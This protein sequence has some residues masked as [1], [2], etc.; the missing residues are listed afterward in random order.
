MGRL[1]ESIVVLMMAACATWVFAGENEVSAVRI[2]GVIFNKLGEYDVALRWGA[3]VREESILINDSNPRDFILEVTKPNVRDVIEINMKKGEEDTFYLALTPSVWGYEVVTVR[4]GAIRFVNPKEAIEIE[5]LLGIIS[6]VISV[7]PPLKENRTLIL[8]NGQEV[9]GIFNDTFIMVE[10]FVIDD[11]ERVSLEALEAKEEGNI[12]LSATFL[13]DTTGKLNVEA[14]GEGRFKDASLGYT[15]ERMRSKITIQLPS[16]IET[17]ESLPTKVSN[18]V[19]MTSETLQRS[20]GE[21]TE[22]KLEEEEKEITGENLKTAQSR[23]IKNIKDVA[24]DYRYELITLAGIFV[25][26]AVVR[27]SLGL[28][29]TGAI[30]GALTLVVPLLPMG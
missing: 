30:I 25:V 9:K 14:K 18:W 28:A 24:K 29:M 12:Y 20:T 15:Y 13:L 8:V 11:G 23:I 10:R 7:N 6:P 2:K 3:F 1:T 19:I 21:V 17:S 4:V 26:A 22:F 27:R 16:T 5:E